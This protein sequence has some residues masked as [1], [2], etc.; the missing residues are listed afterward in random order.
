MSKWMIR[1]YAAGL[2]GYTA[3]RTFDFMVSQLPKAD[4]SIY[5]AL[6]FLFATELGLVMWHELHLNH[7]TTGTQANLATIMTWLDF[8]GSLA[9]GVADMILRQTMVVYTIPPWLALG[10]MFGLPT[11]FAINVAAV[12]VFETQDGDLLLKHAERDLLFETHKNALANLHDSRGK[13]AADYQAQLAKE[14]RDRA[15]MR[16]T[17]RDQVPTPP[18]EQAPAEQAPTEQAPSKNGH[19]PW[20]MAT[21]PSRVTYNSEAAADPGKLKGPDGHPFGQ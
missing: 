6:A 17:R 4:L 18:T 13:F 8:T 19:K 3:W 5:L 15:G 1:I 16:A 9:A 12:I 7:V 20:P 14:V 2:L 10:L 21:R 11:L